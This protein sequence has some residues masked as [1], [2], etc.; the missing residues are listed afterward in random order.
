MYEPR[1]KSF[2]LPARLPLPS[3]STKPLY[4][5]GHSAEIRAFVNR[6]SL[7]E[8]S[9]G[10]EACSPIAQRIL[11]TREALYEPLRTGE[12]QDHVRQGQ[13]NGGFH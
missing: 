6:N 7:R 10:A 4:F 1:K 12:V 13:P 8:V 11:P 2:D 5:A 3:L 9:A